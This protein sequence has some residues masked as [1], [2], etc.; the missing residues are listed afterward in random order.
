MRRQ[1]NFVGWDFAG[2]PLDG[3][4]DAWIMPEDGGYPLLTA[5]D[6]F[7]WAGNGTADDPYLVETAQQFMAIAC[8]PQA[9]YRLEADIDLAGRSFSHSVVP[10]LWGHF[11]GAGH[12][13]SNFTLTGQEDVGLFGVV[14]PG[15][16][17]VALHLPS[18]HVETTGSSQR[19]IAALAAR[20][21]G[22]VVGCTAATTMQGDGSIYYIGGLAGFNDGGE[23]RKCGARLA[24]PDSSGGL[25]DCGGLVG[26]NTGAVSQCRASIFVHNRTTRVGGLVGRN[27]GNITDCYAEG[28]LYGFV[29]DRARERRLP[30]S[31]EVWS[32]RTRRS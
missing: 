3:S 30:P 7:G 31:W 18:V 14:Y 25:Y 12:N 19:Q 10:T 29:P 9:C 2:T 5:I 16:T 27:D 13:V 28:Y 1:E 32:V 8:E 4:L 11:D 20:N 21:C 24:F 17:V 26:H 23:I 15:A 6:A 22:S